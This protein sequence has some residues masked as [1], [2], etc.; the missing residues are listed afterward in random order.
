[1]NILIVGASSRI[2]ESILHHIK[3]SGLISTLSILDDQYEANIEN[4]H[5]RVHRD[6]HDVDSIREACNNKD[7]VINASSPFRYRKNRKYNDYVELTSDVINGCLHC[8]VSRYIHI[9]SVSSIGAERSSKVLLTEKN[10]WQEEPSPSK[11]ALSH[12]RAEQQVWRGSAEG[13]PSILLHSGIVLFKKDNLSSKLRL[14]DAQNLANSI[15]TIFISELLD[16]VRWATNC[17]IE[18]RKI[19]C[20]SGYH[21]Y[22]TLQKFW[23]L[24]RRNTLKRLLQSLRLLSDSD[25]LIEMEAVRNLFFDQT[26]Y[27]EYRPSTDSSSQ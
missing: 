2:G 17:P 10:Y 9:G 25:R 14:D 19:H 27:N 8:G 22:D 20:V 1:M 26:S 24:K 23:G 12:F 7:I 15:P 18:N 16:M 5:I 21:S 11:Y 6:I 4:A 13:L 3:S